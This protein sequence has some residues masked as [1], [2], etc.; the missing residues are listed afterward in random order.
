VSDRREFLKGAGVLGLASWTAALPGT[1]VAAAETADAGQKPQAQADAKDIVLENGEMRLVIG[2]NG[3]ARSLIHKPTGQEC[4]AGDSDE[5][6]FALTQDRPYDNELQLAYPAEKAHFPAKEVTYENGALTV[7]FDL[8]GYAA[9]IPVTITE[10]YI[11]FRLEKLTYHGYTPLQVK[12]KTDVDG[13]M[14]LQLPVRERKNFGQW[15]NVMWDDAVAVNLLAAEPCT[16]I[17]AEKRSGHYV[18]RADAVADVK[19]EGV[20]AALIATATPH[21]LDRIAKVEEDF[22]LP[23]G[24]KSRRSKEYGTSYYEALTITPEDA[25]RNIRYAKMAGLRAMNVYY[26]SFASSSGHY[27]WRPEYPG[28]MEDLKGV[29]RKIREA[30]MIPGLHMHYN[31]AH[32]S[33]PYVAPVP[34]PRLNLSRSFTL[35]ENIDAAATTIPVEENPRRCTMDD[36]RRIVRIQNELIEYERYTTTAPYRFENCTRGTLGTRITAHEAGSRVGLLDIDNWPVFVRYTQDTDIQEEVAGRLAE[37]YQ[38]GGFAFAYFDG[39]ED[40]APPFW[41]GVSRAQWIVH[42]KLKPAPLW[43]EGACKS[44]FSWHI[45]TRGNAFDMFKPEV[46]KAATRAYPAEEIQRAAK[47]F[48]RINFGW[49]GYWAPG[50][51]TIGT[52]PDMLEY[53]TSR[54]AAWD[55]PIALMSNLEAMDAHP[56][57]ADNLEVIRRWEEVRA[58]GWLT[59]TMK[60]ELRNLEQEHTLLVD[61]RGEFAL[62]PC[63]QVEKVGGEAAPGRAFVFEYR[64]ATW[65][66]YWHTAGSGRLTLP[67]AARRVKLMREPGTPAATQPTGDPVTLPLEGKMY[68]R[69]DGLGPREVMAAFEKATISGA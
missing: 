21:L 53:V 7:E 23:E 5:P 60:K 61:E 50:Q 3:T 1:A 47:D 13:L 52:Q 37:L 16:R 8:V 12:S 54:G 46:M 33:D 42:Q 55:C 69:F 14:L 64:G 39:A 17:R 22:E 67:V 24:V 48:T 30:G 6:M 29:V 56:R 59:E 35:S 36:D 18:F 49:I 41:Y 15:L 38:Q 51:D 19:L 11:A 57:T 68:L 62:V 28:K 63:T 10:S 4:L 65:A 44:H 66:S 43:A 2:A 27:P 20:S 32:K 45:L 25:E 34:D 58:K 31:K 26:L 40:V 9:T